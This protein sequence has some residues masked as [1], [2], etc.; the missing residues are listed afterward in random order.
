MLK[1]RVLLVYEVL[2]E[3]Y[4]KNDGICEGSNIIYILYMYVL[5]II[6]SIRK[7]LVG[8]FGDLATG[9]MDHFTL[10]STKTTY[11]TLTVQN[12]LHNT[13]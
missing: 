11:N 12:K 7:L 2:V 9:Q 6:A 3:L 8:N 1:H 5:R 10:D 13:L 4:R